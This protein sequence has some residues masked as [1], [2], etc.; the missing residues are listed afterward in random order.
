LYFIYTPD[1]HL[2]FVHYSSSLTM[3]VKTFNESNS[4]IN[5][6]E[7]PFEIKPSIVSV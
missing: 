1:K 5:H 7:Y 6:N 2:N 3:Y 4:K